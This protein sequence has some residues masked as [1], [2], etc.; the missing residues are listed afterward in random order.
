MGFA[1]RPGTAVDPMWWTEMT[2]CPSAR[3]PSEYDCAIAGHL[4]S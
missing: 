2:T 1:A 4:G 3:K